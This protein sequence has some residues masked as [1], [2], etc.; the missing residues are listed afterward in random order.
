MS[1]YTTNILGEMAVR[2]ASIQRHNAS[3]ATLFEAID[4]ALARLKAGKSRKEALLE[5]A[6]VM[7]NIALIVEASS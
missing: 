5:A 3:T 6:S 1:N 2:A 7:A 4:A